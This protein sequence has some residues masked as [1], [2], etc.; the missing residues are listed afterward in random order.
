MQFQEF[1]LVW[2]AAVFSV[3]DFGRQRGK[4][5]WEEGKR[6]DQKWNSERFIKGRTQDLAGSYFSVEKRVLYEKRHK[7]MVDTIENI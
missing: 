1:L 2:I 6:R 5:K 7:E 3:S 4:V